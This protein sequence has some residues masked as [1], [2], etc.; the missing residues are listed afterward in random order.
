[1]RKPDT[2]SPPVSLVSLKNEALSLPQVLS[3][4]FTT[5]KD[6]QW[7]LKLWLREDASIPL[8]EVERDRGDNPVIYTH[9]PQFPAVAGPAYPQRGE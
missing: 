8:E 9:E 3:A 5:T 6:G 7:A 4:G 2:P 1:M